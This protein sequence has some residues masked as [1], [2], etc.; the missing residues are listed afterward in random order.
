MPLLRRL[1]LLASVV[2]G[3]AL[4]ASP[5]FATSADPALTNTLG[6]THFLV[7]FTSDTAHAFALTATDAADIGNAAEQDLAAEMANGYPAPLGDG[8]LGGDNRID[9]YVQ[10]LPAGE[11]GE[12]D[13]D[14]AGS[15]SGYILLDAGTGLDNH[16]ISHELFHLIQFGYWASGDPTDAWLYEAGAE[17]MG[18]HADDYSFD[19]HQSLAVGHNDFSL[20][21]RDPVAGGI[22]CAPDVYYD[23]GYSRW[24]FFEYVAEKYGNSFLGNV[25]AQLAVQ[26]DG[27]AT[28]ALSSALVATGSTLSDTYNGWAATELTA[29]YSVSALQKLPPTVYGTLTTGGKP[30]SW[31]HHIALNHL[32]MRF[33]QIDRGPSVAVSACYAATLSLTVTIPAGISSKPVFWWN[34]AGNPPIPLT[35]NGNTAVAAI[36]WD[37]CT[38]P[39]NHGYLVIPNA[40]SGSAADAA[41]FIV[42]ASMSV[43]TST[44]ATATPP[45]APADVNTPVVAVPTT[46]DYAPDTQVLGSE[47]LHLSQGDTTLRLIVQSNAEG[48]LHATLGGVDLGSP[49]IRAGANDVRLT[50]PKGT[51]NALRKTAAVNL[52]TLTT[53]S[54][55]GTQT[56]AT[57]TRKVEIAGTPAAKKPQPKPKKH[58]VRKKPKKHA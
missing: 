19:D 24:P 31:T 1:L 9:I 5:A 25:F 12:A 16:V 22:L 7:H 33:L 2:A 15:S 39:A 29:G 17:W 18:Y 50:L 27:H 41:D 28:S 51:L 45:P 6:T 58:P 44:Q 36:P 32:A 21:C 10:T 52:L 46:G 11:S 26:G 8:G 20:D 23:N 14:N 57:V 54:P 38:W 53:I 37:T 49:T 48:K 13:P 55:L 40:S 56:G 4:L 42:S 43:D 34:A 47:I 35:V 3:S 30:F